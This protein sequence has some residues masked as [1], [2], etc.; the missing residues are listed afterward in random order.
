MR[1]TSIRSTI[2]LIISCALFLS[3]PI[4]AQARHAHP[5]NGDNSQWISNSPY[6]TVVAGQQFFLQFTFENNGSTTWS[7]A[8]G[9]SLA[10][11]TY[12]HPS[13]TS[14]DGVHAVNSCMGGTSVSL[15]GQ[16]IEPGQSITFTVSLTAPTDLAESL[17]SSTGIE[18]DA[19]YDMQDN[20]AIF[21]NNNVFV[22]VT[23]IS[24]DNLY[25]GTTEAVGSVQIPTQWTSLYDANGNHLP[26][27]N[28][29][30]GNQGPADLQHHASLPT[31]WDAVELAG[32]PST[33]NFSVMGYWQGDQF[34]VLVAYPD[35]C[36]PGTAKDYSSNQDI[37]SGNGAIGYVNSSDLEPALSATPAPDISHPD[38]RECWPPTACNDANF[39]TEDI[40]TNL[41]PATSGGLLY[42][43]VDGINVDPHWWL[44]QNP[45]NTQASAAIYAR[46][47]SAQP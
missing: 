27:R 2:T 5:T 34:F 10:C 43:W 20:G 7:D 36:E 21:G 38:W 8:N 32:L 33:S 12:Y 4:A 22:A 23:V 13:Y 16:T 19:W 3:T 28:C 35:P 42:A 40:T 29:S 46:D 31:D 45:N 41:Q 11:D 9:Y 6:P 44:I 24:P 26:Q 47:W 15:N 18:Y 39:P 37:T 1:R 30:N 25:Q 14:Y 17:G